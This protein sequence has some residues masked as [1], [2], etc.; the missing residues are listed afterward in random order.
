M[1][2]SG[3][4]MDKMRTIKSFHVRGGGIM[5]TSYLFY[6]CHNPFLTTKVN[7]HLNICDLFHTEINSIGFSSI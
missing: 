3:N 1:L 7:I 6:S 5:D 4:R 2:F